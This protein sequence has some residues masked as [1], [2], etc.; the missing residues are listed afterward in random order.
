MGK[1]TLHLVNK[2]D[3]G[4]PRAQQYKVYFDAPLNLEAR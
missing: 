2:D 3:E 1:S 4:K